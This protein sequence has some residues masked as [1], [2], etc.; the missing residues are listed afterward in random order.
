MGDLS[1]H[2]NR[3]EFRCHHCGV[4]EVDQL[5]VARL[6]L[7]RARVGK[8]L[9]IV[10]GYRCPEHNRA[11]GGAPHSQ[12]LSGRAVDPVAGYCDVPTAEK[13][14]FR[15]IGVRAGKVVHLDVR[16]GPV[17]VFKD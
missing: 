11:V 10:S 17:V 15:G 4:V 16:A 9:T 14:G 13:V 3:S 12:H 7:L 2:F 8:P 5:L 6:E 1:A